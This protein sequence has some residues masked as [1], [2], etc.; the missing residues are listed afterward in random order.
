MTQNG[1]A[2]KTFSARFSLLILGS[3]VFSLDYAVCQ[4]LRYKVDKLQ[5]SRILEGTQ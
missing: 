3:N 2:G 4:I 1:C 5:R